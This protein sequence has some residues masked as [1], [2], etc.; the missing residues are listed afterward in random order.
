MAGDFG[1]GDQRSQVQ[2]AAVFSDLTQPR[3]PLEIHQQARVGGMDAV[4]EG[5]EEVGP[6]GNGH[7]LAGAPLAEEGLRLLQRGRGGV[8]EGTQCH[9]Y[10]F[11]R[12]ASTFC[13]VAGISSIR[14]PM[15]W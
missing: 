7:R 12:A 3:Q 5:P 6:S 15:A 9:R 14:T 13:G 2:A 10:A 11:P 4:F 1:Q 8:R